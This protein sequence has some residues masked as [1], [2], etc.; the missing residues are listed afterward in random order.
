MGTIEALSL[1]MG[2]A[3]TSGINLYA[4]VAALG[5]AGRAEMIRLPPD[6]EVLTHPA[7]IAIACIMYV[8]EFFADKVPYVDSGWDVLHTFI[9]VPAGAI[10]A[11]RSLGD[12]NPA[13]EL[14]ALLAGGSIALVAHGAKATTRLA[15]N[16]SPEPFSNWAASFT[17]DIAVLGSIWMIFNHPIIMIGLILTFLAMVIWLVPRILRAAKRGFQALR[18]KLRGV[19]PD[20]T[21]PTGPSP[22]PT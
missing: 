8:I 18:N 3:W 21:T 22:Q 10:L 5:I 17:E 20:Q 7:V 2:T 16:A 12:M 11:A 1:A 13:L 19:K 9:R 14:A 4:T 15:I 6:L